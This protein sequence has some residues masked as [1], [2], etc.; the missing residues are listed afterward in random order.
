MTIVFNWNNIT[1]RRNSYGD[2]FKCIDEAEQDVDIDIT[3]IDDL[4]HVFYVFL[5]PNGEIYKVH[6]DD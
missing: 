6:C 3:T 2:F 5:K 1:I 4:A